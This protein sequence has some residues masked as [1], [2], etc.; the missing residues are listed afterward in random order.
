MQTYGRNPM[1]NFLAA[2]AFVI[3]AFAFAT[4]ANAA[5]G[6]YEVVA[7]CGGVKPSPQVIVV[8]KKV[9]IYRDHRPVRNVVKADES[10]TNVKSVKVHS[11]ALITGI[12]CHHNWN[13]PSWTGDK[14]WKPFFNGVKQEIE[15]RS[16]CTTLKVKPGT[17]VGTW[18]VCIKAPIYSFPTVSGRYVMRPA[19]L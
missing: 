18:D 14:W 15:V 19:Q 12:F 11:P 8:E 10:N 6:Q 13:N 3:A 1:R 7:P 16:E 9:Y 5:C 4:P 17:R 2:F